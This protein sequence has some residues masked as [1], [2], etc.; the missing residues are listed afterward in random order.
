MKAELEQK[1][2]VSLAPCLLD[3]R[4][5]DAKMRIAMALEGYEVRKEETALSVYDGDIN[6]EIMKRFLMAKI[7]RG[8]SPRTIQYYKD[9]VTFSLNRIGKPYDEVTADDIRVYLAL[10]VQRDGVSKAT[11]NNERRNLSAFYS[12]LQKEEILSRNPMNRVELIKVTKTQKSAY[13]QMEL[14]R[15]RHACRTTMDSAVVEVLISTWARV[16]E[17]AQIK[18]SDIADNRI[19]V[20]GKGDKDREVFLS[21]KA[22][23]AVS[24]YLAER[25]DSNPYLFPRARYAGDVKQLGHDGKRVKRR[26]WY[27]DPDL[28]GEGHRSPSTI[29]ETIRT[30]GKRAGVQ[31]AHP[32][33]FRRTGATFALRNGMPLL[34]VSKMLGHENIGTT[35]IYLDISDKD[36]EQAHERFVI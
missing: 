25:N 30:I 26:E 35:Q 9:S 34:T 2:I 4:I 10:R 21:A 23:M 22:Q 8:C 32:H 3:D 24:V 31:N 29:E 16:S 14:E 1:L 19:I 13:T 12:W 7:A 28:I 5:E 20:H 15:I 36:L 11:A 18:L 6:E 17:I 33:R 27:K